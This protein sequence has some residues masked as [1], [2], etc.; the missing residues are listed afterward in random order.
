MS[1]RFQRHIVPTDI[2]VLGVVSNQNSISMIKLR[3]L[4]AKKGILFGRGATRQ[5]MAECYSQLIISP[6]DHA[7]LAGCSSSDPKLDQS[8][9]VSFDATLSATEFRQL[10]DEVK[11]E[12]IH[13]KN[14]E[15][16]KSSVKSGTTERTLSIDYS[17]YDFTK[18]LYGVVQHHQAQITLSN[19]HGKIYLTTPNTPK[20]QEI[21]K[22]KIIPKI[23]SKITDSEP[24][25]VSISPNTDALTRSSFFMN[26]THDN[27]DIT[28]PYV[29]YSAFFTQDTNSEKDSD[30]YLDSTSL[31]GKNIVVHP[32]YLESI[33]MDFCVYKFRWYGI[34]NRHKYEI[35][36]KFTSA[37]KSSDFVIIVK[38]VSYFDAVSL[39]FSEPKHHVPL[40]ESCAI[41]RLVYD[42]AY[43]LSQA[44]T[45]S[46][47]AAK[48]TE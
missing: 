24:K 20:F 30:S 17:E 43:L 36:A 18:S 46:K 1:G 12:F 11:D 33:E 14:I 44:I 27:P 41:T 28:D 32:R 42:K 26:L 25:F 13:S 29:K 47:T 6:A 40:T 4:L 16:T 7:Y 8:S 31:G 48:K 39:E 34:Y 38:N 9:P 5:Q 35:E 37:N 19:N 15:I 23:Q 2:D 45:A 22:K 10:F 3:S 21:L